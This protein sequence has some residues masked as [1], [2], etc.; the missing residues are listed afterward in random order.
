M[1]GRELL[2]GYVF[3]Y[4][5]VRDCHQ[6]DSCFVLYH[7]E[8]GMSIGVV[9]VHTSPSSH[10]YEVFFVDTIQ[11]YI[12]VFNNGYVDDFFELFQEKMNAV[13]LH[14][15]LFEVHQ[16]IVTQNTATIFKMLASWSIENVDK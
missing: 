11:A 3:K 9:Q 10:E 16:N 12:A 4:S 15:I 2:A 5:R 13:G 6:L 7:E 14:R 8:D 1:F